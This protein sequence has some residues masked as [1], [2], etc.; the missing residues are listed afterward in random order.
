MNLCCRICLSLFL[1]FI[2]FFILLCLGACICTNLYK[3]QQVRKIILA[4]M[5]NIFNDI[6][7]LV[8]HLCI[9]ILYVVIFILIYAAVFYYLDDLISLLIMLGMDV[10]GKMIQIAKVIDEQRY[11]PIYV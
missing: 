7:L 5:R 9:V 11:Q 3:L 10:R 2:I 1:Y 8:E 4:I 6:L